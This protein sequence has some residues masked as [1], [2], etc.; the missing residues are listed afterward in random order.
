[1]AN[2]DLKLENVLL[3]NEPY[4]GSGASIKICDFGYSKHEYNSSARTNVGTPMY[5]SPEIILGGK[6]DAPCADIWSCGV[7][8]YVMLCGRYP[9]DRS[10][11]NYAVRVMQGE[12]EPIDP[13][14]HL[15]GS[16]IDLMN[17]ML[18][19]NPKDRITVDEIFR[20]PWFLCHLSGDILT[21]NNVYWM[22]SPDPSKPPLSDAAEIVESLVARAQCIAHPKNQEHDDE[23][24]LCCRF[25]AAED[26]VER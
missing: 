4:P 15:S 1:M 19:P 8:L 26:L 14:L 20:H 6:Y 13:N 7:M 5:M 18:R 2:R 22:N 12:Y 10:T 21:I 3:T 9:F 17:R 25:P 16:V 11:P 23:D 24:A